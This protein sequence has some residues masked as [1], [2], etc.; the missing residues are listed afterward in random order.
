VGPLVAVLEGVLDPY[1]ADRILGSLKYEYSIRWIYDKQN[2]SKII[3]GVPTKILGTVVKSLIFVGLL[4][5]VSIAVGAGFAFLRFGIRARR[6]SGSSH[7]Q[8]PNEI[9]RL[10][11]R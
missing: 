3:W 6:F 9:I 10:R 7:A 11:L 5:L 1:A 4:C 2:Q 8:D